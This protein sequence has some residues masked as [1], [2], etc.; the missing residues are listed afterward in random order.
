M[1]KDWKELF[2]RA[3][4]NAGKPKNK[5]NWVH[6]RDIAGVG[7]TQ[8]KEICGILGFKPE[9]AVLQKMEAVTNDQ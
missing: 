3:L 1:D 9:S 4:H 2:R 7:S 6:V 5:L 8:A